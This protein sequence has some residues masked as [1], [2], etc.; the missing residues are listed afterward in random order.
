MTSIEAESRAAASRNGGRRPSARSRIEA[1]AAAAKAAEAAM[2]ELYANPLIARLDLEGLGAELPEAD[3]EAILHMVRRLEMPAPLP[4][5][6]S[7]NGGQ[8]AERMLP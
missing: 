7:G 4:Q 6:R 2:G 3:L 1:A 8:H 5:R